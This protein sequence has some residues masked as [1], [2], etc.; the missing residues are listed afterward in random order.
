[1][2]TDKEFL[3]LTQIHEQAGTTR[4]VA[5]NLLLKVKPAFTTP[6]G[7]GIALFYHRADVQPIIDKCQARLKA[8]SALPTP[9]VVS[10]GTDALVKALGLQ[11]Q[12]QY[13]QLRTDTALVLEKLTAQNRSMHGVID[14]QCKQIAVLLTQLGVKDIP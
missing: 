3:G 11:M 2:S 10:T 6:Y 14:K 13:D 4:D 7:R 5:R 8:R 1:M 9:P 12:T